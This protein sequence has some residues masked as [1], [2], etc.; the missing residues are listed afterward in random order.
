MSEAYI[1]CNFRNGVSGIYRF[2][3]VNPKFNGINCNNIDIPFTLAGFV[4][5]GDMYDLDGNKVD[6]RTFPKMGECEIARGVLTHPALRAVVEG[7]KSESQKEIEAVE[8]ASKQVGLSIPQETV[9]A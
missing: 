5:E 9:N 2:T 4:Y 1:K 7:R 3:G 8:K 6:G